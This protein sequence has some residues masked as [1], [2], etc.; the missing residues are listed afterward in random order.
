MLTDLSR[1]EHGRHEGDIDGAS[2]S[3]GNPHLRTGD[4]IGYA[5]GGA[6]KYVVP[7]PE[8]RGDIAAWKVRN[9]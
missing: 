8:L 9:Q 3:Q 2:P 5:I 1:N 7:A 4:V 6:F